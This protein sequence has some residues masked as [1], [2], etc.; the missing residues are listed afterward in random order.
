MIEINKWVANLFWSSSDLYPEAATQRCSEE[1]VFW[2]Y[3]ENFGTLACMFSC[4]FA[5]YF[6]NTFS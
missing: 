3:A 4:K 6:Q 1:K 2:K 5:A